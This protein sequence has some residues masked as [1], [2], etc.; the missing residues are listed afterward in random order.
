MTDEVL[1]D[2]DIDIDKSMTDEVLYDN[3]IDSEKMTDEVLYDNDINHDNE[4][5]GKLYKN[6]NN[7]SNIIK[8]TQKK[9]SVIEQMKNRKNIG[10]DLGLIF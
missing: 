8:K 4:K 1:Y 3:D 5:L 10:N 7:H 2:N 6:E 9:Q